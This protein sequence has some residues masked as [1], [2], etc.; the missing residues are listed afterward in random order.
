MRYLAAIAILICVL[1]CGK[2][3]QPTPSAATATPPAATPAPTDI[4]GLQSLPTIQPPTDPSEILARVGEHT[5]SRSTA[6]QDIDVRVAA[7][8]DR[9]PPSE[10]PRVREQ[11]LA[12]I[13]EQFVIRSVLLDE[14]KAQKI[15]VTPDDEQKA[16][17]K[18]EEHLKSQGR[19]LQ[20]TL[21]NSPI[22]KDRMIEEVHVGITIDKLMASRLADV[23]EPS[24]EEIAAF[25]Q[26]NAQRLNMPERVHARH[27]LLTVEES[28]DEATRKAKHDEADKLRAD[29][30]GGADFEQVAR[31][32]SDCPSSA[33]GGD[34]GWFGRGQM[35]KPFEDAAFNQA[36]NDIGPVIETQFGYHIVQVLEHQSEG[37]M[38]REDL[39][40]IIKQRKRQGDLKNLLDGLLAKAKIEYADSIKAL[41][42][43]TI[44]PVAAAPAAPAAPAPAA[45]APVAEPEAAPAPAPV[46]TPPP[47]PEAAPSAP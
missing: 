40:D 19:S 11:T 26:E 13:I 29:L 32:H 18:I 10:M 1:G 31:E 41:V 6:D 8:A 14:A 45:P 33:R 7:I 47:A 5:L 44:K 37:Q 15:E 9:V 28:A 39:I 20:E 38:P 17:A 2:N 25:M 21:E 36:T 42:P 24:E 16:F 27:I 22:G 12:K 43:D 30:A 46:A 3:P 23:Q 35:V 4:A 34:L